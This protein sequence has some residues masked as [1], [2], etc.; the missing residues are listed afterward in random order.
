MVRQAG[1]GLEADDVLGAA[2]DEVDHIPREEPAFTGFMAQG[3]VFLRF[4]SDVVNGCD[5]VE[6]AALGDGLFVRFAV[7]FQEADGS[8]AEEGILPAARQVFMAE[9]VVQL[10]VEEEVCQAGDDD[11]AAFF[12][13]HA[14]DVVIGDGVELD[15][16]FTDQADARLHGFTHVD[17]VEFVDEVADISLE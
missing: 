6:M 5:R 9:L 11:F 10:A 2:V 16:D 4:V 3:Q 7:P 17:V 13:N 12:F 14:D 15:V 8:L 1:P